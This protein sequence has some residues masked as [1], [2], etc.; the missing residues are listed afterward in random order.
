MCCDVSCQ[1]E[2]VTAMVYDRQRA[3]R[4]PQLTAALLMPA[5]L[6]MVHAKMPR[7]QTARAEARTVVPS[8]HELIET[9]SGET[10]VVEVREMVPAVV[11]IQHVMAMIPSL[12]VAPVAIPSV[13]LVVLRSVIIMVI[14]MVMVAAMATVMIMVAV[15]IVIVVMIMSEPIPSVM[16][17]IVVVIMV[18][19]M[20]EPIPPVMIMMVVMMMVVISVAVL[21]LA[22]A[23]GSVARRHDG[24]GDAS[25]RDAFGFRPHC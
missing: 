13:T 16:V 18:M 2:D 5:W 15:I 23:T 12:V 21:V 11:V 1:P 14:V 4:A 9:A 6:V 24:V 22:L 20:S 25:G 8:N 7:M 19:I 17:A 3:S 10:L